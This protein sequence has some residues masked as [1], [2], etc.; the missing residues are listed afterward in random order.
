MIQI[1]FACKKKLLVKNSMLP[2]CLFDTN[3]YCI[4]K[5]KDVLSNDKY[6]CEVENNWLLERLFYCEN[7]L[8]NVYVYD[9]FWLV[10]LTVNS[11]QNLQLTLIKQNH[12]YLGP[13]EPVFIT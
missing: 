8:A 3:E 1:N 9:N 10:S 7:L 11:Q 4:I 12:D 5:I 13:T 6:L 2:L